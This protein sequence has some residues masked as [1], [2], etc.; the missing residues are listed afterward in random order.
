M[1]WERSCILAHSVGTMQ[2][3]LE[4]TVAFAKQRVQFD[5]PIG[6]FQAV[7]HKIVDMKV[8]LEAGRLLLYNLGWLKSQGRSTP[9]ETAITKLFLAES[10]VESSLEAIQVQGANGYMTESGVER[11]LRDALAAKLYSGTSE[12][13]RNL[14]ARYLGL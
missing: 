2:R 12:V 8:R 1:D 3:Q 13:Q 9:M 6:K 5:Q 10:W 7:S 11:N 4:E 14:I